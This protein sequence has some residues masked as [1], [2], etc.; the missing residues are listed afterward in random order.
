MR[1]YP[2]RREIPSIATL[3]VVCGCS[4][5]PDLEPITAQPGLVGTSTPPSGSSEPMSSTPSSFNSPSEALTPDPSPA[6]ARTLTPTARQTPSE[7]PSLS[8]STPPVPKTD[9]QTISID[10]LIYNQV[11]VANEELSDVIIYWSGTPEECSPRFPVYVIYT[12]TYCDP[13]WSCSSGVSTVNDYANPIIVH[14]GCTGGGNGST[15]HSEYTIEILD[16]NSIGSNKV[17]MTFTCIN[18]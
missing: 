5:L 1:L 14:H 18:V 3:L 10:D 7:T 4:D 8:A 2:C 11:S 15:Y 13:G 9:C 6:P 16:S 12:N 17:Q